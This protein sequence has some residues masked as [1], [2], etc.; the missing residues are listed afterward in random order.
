M[1]L[2]SKGIKL[3]KD[4]D[5][6]FSVSTQNV[7]GDVYT[8]LCYAGQEYELLIKEGSRIE[9]YTK[10]AVADGIPIYASVTGEFC[11]VCTFE[12]GDVTVI[13]AHI[14]NSG[15]YTPPFS[16][17]S[18]TD[19]P[20]SPAELLDLFKNAAIIDT[21][22][23]DYLCNTFGKYLTCDSLLLFA[24]DDNPYVVTSCAVMC[25]FEEE[26]L[27]GLSII[28]RSLKIKNAVI[29]MQKNFK[30][31]QF[32][33]KRYADIK[34][35]RATD[36]YPARLNA[37]IYAKKNNSLIITPET[38]RAVYRAAVFKE[39]CVTKTVTVWGDAIQKPAAAQIPIGT[40]CG[41]LLDMFESY[42]QID[43]IVANGVMNGYLIMPN[44][45]ITPF[46]D[47]ITVMSDCAKMQQKGCITCGRCTAVCP[48]GLAPYYV[49]RRAAR[50]G[51]EKS[52]FNFDL[53]QKCGCC[54]YVC[55]AN[56]PLDTYI[57]LYNDERSKADVQE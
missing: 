27:E 32:F 34:V 26:V 49:L 57:K 52:Y 3:H 18:H 38:C 22:N 48:V 56:I 45:I 35:M 40:T 46:I 19:I 50:E 21:F 30:T 28:T 15:E 44:D 39:P 4:L 23:K 24:V 53:C 42:T 36:K 1:R 55:P 12:S 14:K 33:K 8:F 47:S 20:S 54:S 41:E 7:T 6:D 13:A 2:F 16:A 10:I 29:M 25:D 11:G 43:K 9:K 31:A 37:L 5:I 17:L 51:S